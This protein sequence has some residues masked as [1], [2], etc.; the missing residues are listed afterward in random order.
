M[1]TID[2]TDDGFM[3]IFAFRYA[4]GRM[5]AAPSHCADWLC[6]HWRDLPRNAKTIIIRELDDAFDRDDEQ[7]LQERERGDEKSHWKPLG[8]DC[9]RAQWARVRALYRTPTCRGCGIQLPDTIEQTLHANGNRSCRTCVPWECYV[10]GK[11]FRSLEN[12]IVDPI[13]MRSRHA[14]KCTGASA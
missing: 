8:W 5:S 2:V 6:Q 7:R 13:T 1:P 10:C 9:D 11:E 4:L 12:T 14:M 3:V